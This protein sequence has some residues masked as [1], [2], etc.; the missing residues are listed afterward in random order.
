MIKATL[1]TLDNLTRIKVPQKI[2][3]DCSS[4]AYNLRVELDLSLFFNIFLIESNVGIVIISL[5]K[6]CTLQVLYRTVNHGQLF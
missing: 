1:N 6:R 3:V 2:C 5:S 4:I